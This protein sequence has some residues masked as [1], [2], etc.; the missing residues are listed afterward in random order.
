M[1]VAPLTNMQPQSLTHKAAR[2]A[3]GAVIASF[4]GRAVGVFGTLAMT[5]LLHPE[6]IGEV[7]VAAILSMTASWLTTWGFGQYTVVN[8]RGEAA[9][10]VTWHATVFYVGLGAVSLGLVVLFGGRLAPLLDAPGAAAYVPGMALAVFIRRLGAVAERTLT[11]QMNFRAPV[12]I[13]VVGEVAY[14]ATALLL[15]ALG[16]GGTAIVIGNIVQSSLVVVILI[17]AAGVRSWATPTPLRW[18]RIKDMLAYGLPLG[19]QGIAHNAA[20]YWDNLAISHLFGPARLGTYNLAYNLA[21][22]PAI[23]VGEQISLVLLPSMAALPHDRRARALERTT[24]LLSIIIFPLAIGLGLVADPLI[25]VILPANEWQ[26]V[27]P[28]LVV[29]ACLSIFRPITWVLSAYMEAE[30]KTAHLMVIELAKVGLLLGGI[31]MLAPFGLRAASAAVGLAYG[32]TAIASVAMVARTGPSPGRLV[33][34]FVMPLAACAVMLAAVWLVD[35]ALAR[36]GV[37]HPLAYIV[38]DVVVGAITYIAAALVICRDS[39]RD[40]LDLARQAI[41]RR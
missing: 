30:R 21:D 8:A 14:T 7:S 9:R 24:A 31:V 17:R 23:Q 13:L 27:A 6:T 11:Q 20:R 4:T 28:V 5:R 15:A 3:L 29:L 36:V 41:L 18:A 38:A 19:V 35:A 34:G 16:C 12:L 26:E 25:A 32:L 39:A 37:Q 33:L 10:E 40:L 22:I 2:G 1:A